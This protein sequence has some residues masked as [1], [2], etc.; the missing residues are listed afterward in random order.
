MPSTCADVDQ[1]GQIIIAFQVLYCLSVATVKSSIVFFYIRIFAVNRTYR[2]VAYC[3][4][5]FIAAWAVMSV[6]VAFLSCT[7]LRFAWDPTIPGGSCD[8]QVGSFVAE[9]VLDVVAD[10]MVLALPLRP[11]W[12]LQVNRSKKVV[13]FVIFGLGVR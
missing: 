2:M 1:H 11:I 5:A 9:A 4:A 13:L 7:P 12:K 3:V 6:L 8:N 10:L